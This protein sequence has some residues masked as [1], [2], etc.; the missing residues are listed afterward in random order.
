MC[1][2]SCKLHGFT[3]NGVTLIWCSSDSPGKCTIDQDVIEGDDGKKY[4]KIVGDCEAAAVSVRVRSLSP[5]PN[6]TPRQ[7]SRSYRRSR[8]RSQYRRSKSRGRAHVPVI[9]LLS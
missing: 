3:L 9:G 4:L 2:R 6:K 1:M 5:C 7:G 8:S